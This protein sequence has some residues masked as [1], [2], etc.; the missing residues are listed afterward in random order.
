MCSYT[1]A[2]LRQITY[3]TTRLGVYN[4]CLNWCRKRKN[5]ESVSF[6]EKMCCGMIGGACGAVVGNP[7]EITLIRTS[8]DNRLPPEQRRGY[9][10]CI[11]A[12]RAKKAANTALHS[13]ISTATRARRC[14]LLRLAM[15]SPR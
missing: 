10:N 1:A 4:S 3:T 11:Q 6:L 9:T 14:D 13:T 12:S 15:G 2:V 7:A 8:A 5:G